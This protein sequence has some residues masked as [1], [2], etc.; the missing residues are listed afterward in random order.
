MVIQS[1]GFPKDQVDTTLVAVKLEDMVDL[2]FD[3]LSK[4]NM[5]SQTA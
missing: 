2:G 5:A 3:R 4:K 1:N